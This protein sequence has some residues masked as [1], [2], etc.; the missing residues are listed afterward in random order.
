MARLDGPDILHFKWAN[1]RNVYASKFHH[2]FEQEKW[3][4]VTLLSADGKFLKAHRL[5]L[6]A[7]SQYFEVINRYIF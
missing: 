1:Q 3:V 4:D 7:S 6:S 5:I 2:L